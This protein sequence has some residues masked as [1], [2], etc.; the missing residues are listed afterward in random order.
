[1]ANA[2]GFYDPAFFAAE[3]LVQLEKAL[4]FTGRVHRGYE[5]DPQTPGSTINIR[6]PAYFK[7]QSMPISSANTSDLNPDDVSIKLDQWEGV[8]FGLSDK[9][10]AYTTERIINEHI[11]PAA[12]ALSDKM[13]AS[14]QTLARTVPWYYPVTATSGIADI[15]ALRRR[16]FDN[17]VNLGDIHLQLNGEREQYFLSQPEFVRANEAGSTEVQ[18]RGSLGQKFGFGIFANQN[19]PVQQTG[20]TVAHNL[21]AQ[22]SATVTAMQETLAIVATGTGTLTGTLKVGDIVQVGHTAVTGLTGAAFAP[23]NTFTD[24]ARNYLVTEDATAT[25]NAITVKVSHK[26]ASPAKLVTHSSGTLVRFK[27][28]DAA[29][30]DNLAF[31]RNAFAFAMAPLPEIARRMGAQVSSMLDPITGLAVRATMWYEG[32]DAKVYVRLDALWGVK[33]LDQDMAVRYIS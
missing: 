4:G 21:G 9:E 26:D 28:G 2:L 7:A 11:R 23:T 10:L 5:K 18:A 12:V 22:L 20:G 13:D 3:A 14:L 30:Y 19:V 15:P 17:A 1:M 8:Q 16:L 29:K 33:L 25:S 31:N 27:V 6:R 24:L 32:L